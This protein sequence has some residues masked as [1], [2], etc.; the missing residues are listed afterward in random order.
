MR[1]SVGR[2]PAVAALLLLAACGSSGSPTRSSTTSFAPP[3]D[4]CGPPNAP[5]ARVTTLRA[6]DGSTL[7]AVEIGRGSTIA[8]LIHQTDGDGLCGFWPYAVRLVEHYGVRSVLFD[9]CRYG[10]AQ[11]R[12]GRFA[13]SQRMPVALAVRW[14]R[15][16]GGTRVVLVGASMG[17]ALALASA[18]PTHADAVVDLSGPPDWTDPDAAAVAPHLVVPTL[19]ASSPGDTDTNFAELRAA[20]NRVAAKSRKFAVGNG[21]HGWDLLAD[22]TTQTPTWHPLADTVAQ[23]IIGRYS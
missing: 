6:A 23:W 2:L 5:A 22:Y 8:V 10:Q 12:P 17:G 13:D 11:C 4:R 7:P 1:R 19:V 16:L 18:T 20:F 21:P 3:A 14:A 9:L 15:S